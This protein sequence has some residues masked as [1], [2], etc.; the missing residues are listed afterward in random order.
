[1]RRVALPVPAAEAFAWHERPGAFERLAPPWQ[2]VQ[3]IERTGGLRD[4]ARVTLRLPP[5]LTWALEHRDYVP[6]RQFRDVQR[7]GP[8]AHYEHTHAFAD[9]AGGSVLEDRIEWSLPGGPIGAL[10]SGPVAARFDQL[11]RW[12]HR[13]TALDLALAR[14][15]AGARWAVAVTGATGLVG[16]ALVALLATQGHVVRRVV[17]RPAEPADIAWD[18]ARGMLDP[19]ALEGLD[20]V[21]HLA[22]AG[23]ADR[24][25]TEARKREI[26]DSRVQ[27]TSLLARTLASLARPPR[28]LVSA[29][30]VGWWGDGGDAELDERGAAGAGFLPEVCRA[31]EEAAAAAAAA[32]IR[33]VH[34]RIGIVL[35]PQGGALAPMLPLFRAGAGGPLGSGRQW[36][37]WITLDDLVLAIEHAIATDKL[38]GPFAAVAPE[39]ARVGDVA[40]ALGRALGRPAFAPAPAFA[41]RA[42]LG[43]EMADAMLL[44]G[45]RVRPGRLVASGFVHRD[46][47]LEDALRRLLGR[48]RP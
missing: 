43:R 8:F 31:W 1:M 39:P 33:V 37:S 14:R 45:Q 25:W 42:V 5:G 7:S 18:P 20:A 48:V 4:G 13:L 30:A 26:R 23:I 47:T 46:P 11:F 3:V 15:R 38:A 35:A 34:P 29:S 21:V 44:A 41:L 28:V 9:T 32:G 2:R 24:P 27:G 36:W 16:K 6:G 10:A 40:A 12:R 22:G 17:R 19:A